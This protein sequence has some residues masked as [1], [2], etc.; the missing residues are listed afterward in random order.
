MG[1]SSKFGLKKNE[2]LHN[3]KLIESIFRSTTY[4]KSFPL[5]FIYNKLDDRYQLGFQVLFSVPKK[6]FPRAVDRNRIKRLMR[7]AYRL[8]KQGFFEFFG[9]GPACGAFIFTNKELPEIKTI[10]KA[11]HKIIK[12]L[13]ETL[14]H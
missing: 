14:R 3:E 1:E 5:L 9:D 4:I 8:N 7:E 11:L 10:E 12:G 2:R 6:K 13:H